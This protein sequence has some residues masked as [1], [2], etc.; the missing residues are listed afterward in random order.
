MEPQKPRSPVR[1]FFIFLSARY[2][3]AVK[4]RATRART[5]GLE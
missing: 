2:A 5:R 3:A 1:G 4:P